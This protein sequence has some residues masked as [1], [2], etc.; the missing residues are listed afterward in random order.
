MYASGPRERL[1]LTVLEARHAR[2]RIKTA[3]S[4]TVFLGIDL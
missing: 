4:G 3:G 2:S 1:R